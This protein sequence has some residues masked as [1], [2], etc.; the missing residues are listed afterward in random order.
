[1]FWRIH[2][3]TVGDD[4]NELELKIVAFEPID[5]ARINPDLLLIWETVAKWNAIASWI[6]SGA[7]L[8]QTG[9]VLQRQYF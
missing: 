6:I 5:I 3:G 8:H 2:S 1:M 9:S 7:R 4:V